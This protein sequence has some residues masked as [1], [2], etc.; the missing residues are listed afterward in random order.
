[1]DGSDKGDIQEQGYSEA[2]K[3]VNADYWP[4]HYKLDITLYIPN[5]HSLFP[6]AIKTSTVH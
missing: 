4:M 1:M 2:W 3:H 5:V 6:V